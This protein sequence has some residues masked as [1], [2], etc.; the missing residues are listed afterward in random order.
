MAM[1]S[2]AQARPVAATPV[3]PPSRGF[4]LLLSALGAAS[5]HGQGRIY[6]AEGQSSATCS[7]G[8]NINCSI[9]ECDDAWSCACLLVLPSGM[10]QP[11]TVEQCRMA[12]IQFPRLPPGH[13]D[14]PVIS[15]TAECRW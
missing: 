11:L 15:P 10:R 9:I 1:T 4:V 7:G 3:I 13:F 14:Q 12:S 6:Y 8:P 5:A 2:L